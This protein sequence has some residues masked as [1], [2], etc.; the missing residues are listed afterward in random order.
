M[1]IQIND[2]TDG[3]KQIWTA[4][5]Q[6]RGKAGNEILRGALGA[7]VPALA[8]AADAQEATTLISSKLESYGLEPL[9]FE[10]VELLTSRLERAGVPKELLNIAS[11]I[12]PD[13][14]VAFGRFHKYRNKC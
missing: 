2:P 9:D 8:L 3:R 14:P 5:F 13:K 11:E 1:N 7:F 12:T 4:I 6:V 10:D